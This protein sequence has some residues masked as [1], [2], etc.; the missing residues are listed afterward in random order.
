[1]TSELSL[2]LILHIQTLMNESY[3]ML[4]LHRGFRNVQHCTIDCGH[5]QGLF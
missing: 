1:M 2:Q 3:A 4:A 5:R